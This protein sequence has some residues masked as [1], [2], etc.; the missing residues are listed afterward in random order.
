MSAAA[1]THDRGSP[2]RAY[3][4]LWVALVF[5]ILSFGVGTGWDRAWH[6]THP[7]EDFWSPP[8]LFIYSTDLVAT[9]VVGWITLNAELRRWF[10]PTVRLPLVGIELPGALALPVG[11]FL[12]IGLAGLFDSIW[13]TRFGLDETAWS[14]PHAMLGSGILLG[15]LGFVSCR[16][17]LARHH[18]VSTW[19]LGIF[20]LILLSTIVGTLSGPLDNLRTLDE[21]RA[22]GRIPVLARD[23]NFQH[24]VRIEI[25]WDL[26]RSNPLFLP[27]SAFAVGIAL[28]FG[29]RLVGSMWLFLL[30]AA[31]ATFLG[32]DRRQAELLRTDT[33]PANWLPIPYLVP[34]LALAV[35]SRWSE[36][37]GWIVGGFLYA[38]VVDL[39]WPT[40]ALSP[41]LAAALFPI[42]V[43]LGERLY[44]TVATPGR[45]VLMLVFLVGVALPLATGIIDLNLRARTP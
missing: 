44:R 12:V 22:I 23:P 26:T 28:A 16:L 45:G 14:L 30:I 38:I 29:R 24:L 9:A 3:R 21:A 6:A 31:I 10:G 40:L 41:A 42:G 35:G 1:A 18:P 19:F 43:V 32:T 2:R 7:F 20:G 36:Q 33:H 13:H 39:W 17:A 34:A 11:G 27:L 8:H 4:W 37:V 15:L 5:A 25:R